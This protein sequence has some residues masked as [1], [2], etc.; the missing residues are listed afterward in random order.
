MICEIRD[1]EEE[2]EMPGLMAEGAKKSS[3]EKG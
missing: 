3:C 1:G 2:E